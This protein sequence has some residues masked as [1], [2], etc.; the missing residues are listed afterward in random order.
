MGEEGGYLS[1]YHIGKTV[2]VKS[3]IAVVP[4]EGYN[5]DTFSKVS[6]C[7]LEWVM[8]MNRRNGRPLYIKHALHGGE[9]RVPGTRYRLDGYDENIKTSYEF[10]G[11]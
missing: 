10:H 8:E 7:W 2:F 9:H 1:I 5:N 11:R 3:P 6:I 4:T